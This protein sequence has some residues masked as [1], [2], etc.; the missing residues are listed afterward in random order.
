MT[1]DDDAVAATLDLF[2]AHCREHG[3]RVSGDMRVDEAAASELLGYSNGTLKNLRSEGKGPPWFK[4]H[5]CTYR[6]TDL[7]QWVEDQR[8]DLD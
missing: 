1:G 8:G 6:L 7:A 5:R 4:V 3:V 2:L